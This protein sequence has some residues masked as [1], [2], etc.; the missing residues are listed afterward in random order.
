MQ[1]EQR[2]KFVL[3][4]ED[5]EDDILLFQRASIQLLIGASAVDNLASSGPTHLHT[6]IAP[7]DPRHASTA[8]VVGS[9]YNTGATDDGS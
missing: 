3:L 4:V 8:A 6:G 1:Q 7:N 5:T 2:T 9:W